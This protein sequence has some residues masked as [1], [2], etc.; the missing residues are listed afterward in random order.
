M[1]YLRLDSPFFPDVAAQFI[2]RLTMSHNRLTTVIAMNNIV[3][4]FRKDGAFTEIALT[5]IFYY[6]FGV[7][8]R[9]SRQSVRRS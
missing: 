5:S 6:R 9:T 3:D 1:S 7:F 2:G 4:A 8:R